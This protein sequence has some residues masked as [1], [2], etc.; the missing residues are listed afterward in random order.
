MDLPEWLSLDANGVLSGTP[1]NTDVGVLQLEITAVD[2]LGKLTTQKVTLSVGDV[3]AAPTFNAEALKDWTA[4]PQDGLTTFIRTLNLREVVQVNLKAA[5]DDE[6]LINNDQLNYTISRD[7][8]QT[9]SDAIAGL[10]EISEGTLRI[11]PEGKDNVGI[12]SIQMRATDLQGIQYSESAPHS[13]QH[14]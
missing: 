6:D 7:N 1:T 13:T 11:Q 12:Q 4:Q 8:G 5:F 14:Q 3:N 10:A 2:P 9:W